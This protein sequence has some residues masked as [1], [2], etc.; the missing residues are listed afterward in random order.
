MSIEIRL[1]FF[2]H[3]KLVGKKNPGCALLPQN[4][5]Q[6]IFWGEGCLFHKIIDRQSPPFK[7]DLGGC[8]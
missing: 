3:N 4:M 1:L 6:W 8:C 5:A 2:L 7:G